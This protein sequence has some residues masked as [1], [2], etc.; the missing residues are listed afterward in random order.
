M[1]NDYVC[2]YVDVNGCDCDYG[3]GCDCVCAYVRIEYAAS[4][5]DAH[6]S[7][8]AF[9]WYREER[10]PPLAAVEEGDGVFQKGYYEGAAE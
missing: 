8:Y 6:I 3:Y 7:R 4:L 10:G 9:P 2:A 5:P 1:N